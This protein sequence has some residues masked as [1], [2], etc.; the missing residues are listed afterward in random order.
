MRLGMGV[1]REQKVFDRLPSLPCDQPKGFERGL[2]PP[3]LDLM[4]GCA[5]DLVGRNFGQAQLGLEPR[6]ADRTLADR[7]S[8]APAAILA[9]EHGGELNPRHARQL[10]S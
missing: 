8:L 10:T 1:S 9:A 7:D 2:G 3:L 5:A 6:L 4:H